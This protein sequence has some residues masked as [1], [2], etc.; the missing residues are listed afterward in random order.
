[1]AIHKTN[2]WIF[3]VLEVFQSKIIIYD[4]LR[5]NLQT[6]M[7][8]K[9]ISNM[10]TYFDGYFEKMG[11]PIDEETGRYVK[12]EICGDYPQQNNGYDCGMM[13]LCGIRD[14]LRKYRVW[15]FGQRDINYKRVL[16]TIELLNHQ[17][18]GI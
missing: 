10:V 12:V 11:F 18:Y 3:A 17:I 1:M 2:H 6:Y 9:T 8:D 13:M 16:V 15:S 5:T 4:S 7:R 14:L